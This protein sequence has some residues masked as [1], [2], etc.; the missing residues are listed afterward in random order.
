MHG[1]PLEKSSI[2]RREQVNP[3]GPIISRY[4]RREIGM[5]GGLCIP[6]DTQHG[7][8]WRLMPR[9]TVFHFTLHLRY[10]SRVVYRN[11]LVP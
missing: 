5:H 6:R 3:S 11:V 4:Y 2:E 10:L 8:L 7:G 9:A 1:F